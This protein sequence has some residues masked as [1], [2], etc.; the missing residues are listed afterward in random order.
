MKTLRVLFAAALLCAGTA[1]F[2]EAHPATPRVAR[3]EAAQSRHIARL[4][5]NGR[6]VSVR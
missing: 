4:K 5:H 6:A 2:A 3:R 1:M